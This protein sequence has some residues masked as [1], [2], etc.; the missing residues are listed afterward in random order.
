MRTASSAS[1]TW[2]ASASAS[3]KTA[4]VLMPMRRA[5]RITRQAI[6]PRLAMRIF[7]NMRAVV[8]PSSALKRDV[9]VLL[10]GIAQLLLAQHGERAADA[11]ARAVRHDD[12]V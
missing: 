1:R 3:E 12:V 11:P 4:T 8:D 5:V 6:S 10:P 2:S 7:L 9:G